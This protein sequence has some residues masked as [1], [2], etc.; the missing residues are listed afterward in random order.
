[1]STPPFSSQDPR[2][3]AKQARWAAKA[4]RRQ[5]KAQWHAQKMYYRSYWRGWRR[6]TF[7]GPVI[8]VGIGVI[9]LLMETGQLDPG[10]FWG[11]YAH[12]WPLLLIGLG[13]VLLVEYL[14]D[15][16]RPGIG[17]RPAGGL[18]WLVILL[19]CLGWVSRNGRLVGPFAWE[20][21]GDNNFFSWMG[22]EHDNDVQMN[23]TL[24]SAK[25]TVTI[26]G[27]RGD[28]TL[29]ASADGQL[30]I[31]AH[32]VVHR[33][34]TEAA[35]RV[36]DELKP[37]VDLSSGG[38]VI[39]VPEKDGASVDLTVQMPAAS[40]VNVTDNHGD[41]IADGLGSVQVTDNRGDV[42]LDGISGDAQAHMNHGDFSA[43]AVQGRVLVD[44]SG[45]DVTLSDVQGSAAINGEFFGD[46]HLEQISGAIHYHS[47]M[48]SLDIPRLEGALTLDSG[49]LNVSKA[50]GPMQISAKSK[51]IEMTEIAGDANI[52]DSDG[53]VNL[54]TAAPLGNLQVT[55][56]TGDVVVT[57]PEHAGFSVTG[58]ASSDE[59][60][61]TDFP[62]NIA[63]SGGEQTLEGTVGG[64]GVHLQLHAE[65]GDLELRKGADLTLASAPPANAKHFRV[66][67]GTKPKTSEE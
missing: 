49:D 23:Y 52:E 44:G 51:D 39:T 50:S 35:Q 1:M 28:I 33:D 12:W 2:W 6:P 4:A 67:P 38:A 11:W 25:P 13:G 20:F 16:S 27:A 36:F 45:N 41:V 26:N 24:S 58:T 46:I 18:F 59:D 30:H 21:S 60:V 42:K 29:G 43:H 57:M 22:P 63:S 7:V 61:H 9:A 34:S 40:F 56:S 31:S 64:G 48:T 19:I 47:S 3:Q 37:N 15:W 32:E 8:L 54:V 65:H 55:D 17:H 10:E 53:D 14:L 62:L 66:P 5:A